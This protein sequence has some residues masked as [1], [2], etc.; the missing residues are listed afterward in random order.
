MFTKEEII[1]ILNLPN[2]H[3]GILFTDIPK[4]YVEHIKDPEK[5]MNKKLF[6]S[7]RYNSWWCN[8]VKIKTI[9]GKIK[10]KIIAVHL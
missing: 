1:E 2:I 5:Y 7:L 9:N 8:I 6:F 3:D 4:K 10:I